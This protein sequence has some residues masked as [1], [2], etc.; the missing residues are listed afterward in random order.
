MGGGALALLLRKQVQLALDVGVDVSLQE[1]QLFVAHESSHREHGLAWGKVEPRTTQ[2]DL[3]AVAERP[4]VALSTTEVFRFAV[5]ML[6]V[7]GLLEDPTVDDL[8]EVVRE[9]VQYLRDAV[10]LS[11]F[12]VAP[13]ILDRGAQYPLGMHDFGCRHK[14]LFSLLSKP[15]C[16]DSRLLYHKNSI[17]ETVYNKKQMTKLHSSHPFRIFWFS[18]LLT[19][20]LGVWVTSSLGMNG[21]WLFAIL[22]VLEVTFSFDN[23]VINSKVLATMSEFWQKIFLTVGIFIAVFVV[24]FLLPIVIVMVASGLG[25]G[26]VVDM[27]LNKP[28]E[29]GE[30]LHHAAPMIDAFG[31]AFLLM[32]GLSY[33][34][35][36]QKQTHWIRS[37]EPW[38]AKAGRFENMKVSIMLAAASLIYFLVE[39]QYQSVVLISSILGVLLHIGL[40]LFGSLFHNEHKQAAVKKT[41]MAALASFLYLEVLDASFSF[42]GVIGA[43]AITSSVILIIA[44]LG[45]G[46][47]WVRSLTIF[48]LRSGTLGKYKYLEHGAHW[49]IMALG[50]M[51][52]MKLFHL[53]LPEWATG[54]LGLLFIVTAITSSVIEQRMLERKKAA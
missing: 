26:Q 41:G 3:E 14:R 32:I 38:L 5:N 9:M 35:D 23:A 45:A 2:H 40:E 17:Q 36:R 49:A 46:A 4:C 39:P 19:I 33:F 50:M 24:R 37:I 16:L 29:Y 51:M 12:L 34:M 44:G 15:C 27:A 18:S 11:G 22:V 54:G 7:T 20:A 13:E 48:L 1:R 53:E 30:T 42:D 52:L 6:H 10:P 8:V 31:G 28:K 43:F 21:L 25:L 47:I